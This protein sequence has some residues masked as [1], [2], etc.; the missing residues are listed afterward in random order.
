MVSYPM[1]RLLPLLCVVAFAIAITVQG[2]WVQ[3][4]HE[5]ERPDSLSNPPPKGWEHRTVPAGTLWEYYAYEHF[6]DKIDWV[7]GEVTGRVL[8]WNR[9]SYFIPA[10][11]FGVMMLQQDNTWACIQ[12]IEGPMVYFAMDSLD[13]DGI[14]LRLEAL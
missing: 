8:V 6:I 14:V 4:F 13:G 11:K 2:A 7:T 9:A 5:V 10:Q 12:V 3:E 1:K